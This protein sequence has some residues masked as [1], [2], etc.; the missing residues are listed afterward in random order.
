MLATDPDWMTRL[1]GEGLKKS[2][3]E[4]ARM[5][6]TSTAG[7]TSYYPAVADPSKLDMYKGGRSEEIQS[8]NY[9]EI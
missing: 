1:A 2:L 7:G 9:I 3:L 8:R 5:G 6:A 4:S